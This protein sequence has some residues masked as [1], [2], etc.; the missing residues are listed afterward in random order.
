M[1]YQFDFHSKRLIHLTISNI[2]CNS[3]EHDYLEFKTFAH[4]MSFILINKFC[5][6]QVKVVYNKKL[7]FLNVISGNQKHV[8]LMIIWHTTYIMNLYYNHVL[9]TYS[10]LV[11]GESYLRYHTNLLETR[12]WL[13]FEMITC[14]GFDLFRVINDRI[15]PF[16]NSCVIYLKRRLP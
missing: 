12:K 3:L 13:L 5:S 11:S 14:T 7:G 1:I 9:L 2:K 10:F 16:I 8:G 15:N 6:Q 4:L